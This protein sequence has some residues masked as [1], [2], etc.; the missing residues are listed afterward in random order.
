MMSEPV[1]ATTQEA[2]D[3]EKAMRIASVEQVELVNIMEVSDMGHV[4][5]VDE[6]NEPF[7]RT[8]VVQ[9]SWMEHE[10]TQPSDGCRTP[11]REDSHQHVDCDDQGS[12]RTRNLPCDVGRAVE[13][14]QSPT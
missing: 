2:I 10:K 7:W 13:N 11:A 9:S 4:P 3:R 5:K 12:R 8:V 6:A 14:C 1:A